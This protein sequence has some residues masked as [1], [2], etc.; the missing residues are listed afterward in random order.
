MLRALLVSVL[1]CIGVFASLFGPFNALLFYLWNAYFRPDA[2]SYLGLI[3]ALN[4]SFVIGIYLVVLTIASRPDVPV[5]AQSF[6]FAGFLFQCVLSTMF[7][8][9]PEVSQPFLM[10]FVKVLIIT[11]LITILTTDRAKFRLLLLVIALSLAF[12]SAKQG[13]VNLILAPGSKNDNSM[14]FLGDNNGVAVGMMML[15]PILGALAQ[16][17]RAT[18]EKVGHRFLSIGVI[19]RGI[20]TYSRGGF[21]AAGAVGMLV[22]ARSKYKI[23]ALIVVAA[24]AVLVWNVMPDRFWERM[25]TITNSAEERDDSAASRI[26][27]WY[28]AVDMAAAKPLTGVGLDGYRNSYE[29]YNT[30][31]RWTGERAVHSIWFG[32]LGDL[33][34]PGLVM[35]VA[36]LALSIRSCRRVVAMAKK[37]PSKQEL[38]L[39]A[40]G[41]MGGLV[42]FVVAGSFLP[43][44]YNEM[45]WHFMGLASA[46][47]FISRSE[48]RPAEALVSKPVDALRPPPSK[49]AL[50]P[51]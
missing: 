43:H 41:V 38:R 21:L 39:Y 4:L 32:I 23:R 46:L 47:D 14:P 15:V 13:W 6:L 27:F 11:F 16:T 10:D 17:A 37:D 50:R 33:G 7:S 2:W 1:I 26:H 12:E 25:N 24:V 34:Y 3:Q 49:N 31:P 9:H 40:D 51:R 44:H 5:N 19:L 18:W 36:L 8:E 35:F 29:A 42:A 45:A 48:V 28:V 22:L 30:D 20:S